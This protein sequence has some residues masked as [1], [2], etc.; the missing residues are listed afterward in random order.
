L[1][2]LISVFLFIVALKK[3]TEYNRLMGNFIPTA[4]QEDTQPVKIIDVTFA[5]MIGLYLIIM[6]L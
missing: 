1:F 4:Q 6:L 3:F 2:I 5:V